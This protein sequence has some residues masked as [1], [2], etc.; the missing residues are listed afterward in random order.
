VTI[1]TDKTFD[2]A[3][4]SE[5]LTAG[6]AGDESS[7]EPA[8]DRFPKIDWKEAFATDFTDIDWLA[9]KFCERGQQITI[10]GDGKVGKTLLV[11]NWIYNAITG[12]SF[13]GDVRRDPIKVLYFDRE[14]SLRDI[15]TRMTAFG[16]TH[17]EL[18]HLDYRM[19]PRFNGALDNSGLAAAEL[20]NI[21]DETKP[22]VVV[23]D[24]VSRFIAGKENDSDTWLELYRR[25]HVPLK[26]RMVATVR[27]DH[28]GKDSERGSRGSSAK[29]Q[30]VDAV[31]ELIRTDERAHTHDDTVEQVTQLRFRRTHTRS[32]LG[33]DVFDIIRR[34]VR[35][36]GGMWLAGGTRHE[37]CD[38]GDSKRFA[39][40]IQSYVDELVARGAP[41]SAGRDA[42]KKWAEAHFV[43][44]P[45]NNQKLVEVVRALK[46]Q[47]DVPCVPE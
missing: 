28:M 46:I 10:V 25:L 17:E 11:H 42:L 24:T 41:Q 9:G 6:M 30:D 20:L 4:L 1:A 12:R 33:D 27:L 14:N 45:K 19:F 40:E 29:T 16:A 36:K 15:V 2:A 22:D 31:W 21:V 8:E 35:E 7:D 13:I 18:E 44:L 32:G 26:E 37:L 43:N 39:Q 38:S 47:N 23:L 3:A 34:G 5:I